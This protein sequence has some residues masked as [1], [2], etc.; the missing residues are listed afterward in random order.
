VKVIIS[1]SNNIVFNLAT[2][3]YLF[4]KSKV[5]HPILFLWRNDKTI[6]IGK[7]QNPW[8]ECRTKEMERDGINLA[9]RKS[10]GGAVYQDLGNTCFSFLDPL[11]ELP[12]NSNFKEYNTDVLIEA[13]KSLGATKAE[14]GGRNDILIEGKKVSGSA[15]KFNP[16]SRILHHGTM[17]I[18]LDKSAANKYLNPNLAKLKSKGVDSVKS[19]IVN[20]VEVDSTITHERFCEAI[21]KAYKNKH[22]D[23]II[24]ELTL[25]ENELHKIPEI[26]QVYKETSTW[27]WRFGNTPAFS[28]SLERKFDWGMVEV[29]L[30][31]EN[32]KIVNGK[33]FSDCLF[34]D[35]IDTLNKILE[36]PE[37][38]HTMKGWE[39]IEGK[40]KGEIGKNEM[41]ER[42]LRDITL[43]VHERI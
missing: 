22:K 27:Q 4:E 10:G 24:E 18:N 40:M 19:R 37:A 2:E 42:F 34:P 26:E 31:V 35:F 11:G 7:H 9:R 6:V 16:G 20:L 17:L 3:E 5:L 38:E 15:Y 13:L 12:T 33:V 43:L 30:A 25:N 28:Y 21:I 39:K 23:K 1:T 41:Y 29:C 8:K 14:K 36:R 32:A